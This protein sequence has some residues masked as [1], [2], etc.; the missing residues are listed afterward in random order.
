MKCETECAG[1]E[2]EKALAQDS[3]FA[4]PLHHLVELYAARGD[5]TNLRTAADRYFAANPGVSRDR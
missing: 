5:R 4:A 1:R 3:L 2:Y